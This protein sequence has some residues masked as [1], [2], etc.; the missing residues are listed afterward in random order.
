VRVREVHTLDDVFEIE[1]AGKP[2]ITG[3][4][5]LDGVMVESTK[6]AERGSAGTRG[7]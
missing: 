4:E 5:G 6:H 1:V 3:S 7:E 2:I